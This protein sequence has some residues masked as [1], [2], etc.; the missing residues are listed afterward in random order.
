MAIHETLVLP[1]ERDELWELARQIGVEHAATRL[2]SA[3]S[4]RG[5]ETAE[6]TDET[7]PWD[8]EPLMHLTQRFADAGFELVAIEDIYPPL[9]YVRMGHDRERGVEAMSSLVE[10]LGALDVPVLCYTWSAAFNWVRTSTTTPSRGDSLTTSYDHEL[11]ERAPTADT[12]I[13]ET[14]LWENLEYFLERIVPVAEEAGVRLALHP[15]DPPVSPVRGVP[16]ILTSPDAVERAL[17]LVDS[18]HHGITFCQGT[19]GAMGV[20][21]PRTIRRFADDVYYVHLRDVDGSPE[22]FVETWHDDGPTDMVEAIETWREVGFDGPMR[23]DHV[24][25]MAGE[26]NDAPGYEAKGRLFA[27]GY[28]RGLLE[29]TRS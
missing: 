12:S 4:W 8:F 28:M 21:L 14:E 19:F 29:A 7:R 5:T 23:P 26:S 10:H 17:G 13:T 20:D 3:G 11:L 27:I 16:R 22:Q 18:D 25:T 6:T 1:P 15:D 9:E 2:P 24:P